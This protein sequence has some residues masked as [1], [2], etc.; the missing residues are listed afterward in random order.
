[1]AVIELVEGLQL[2]DERSEVLKA[3]QDRLAL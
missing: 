2:F 3:V 1:M